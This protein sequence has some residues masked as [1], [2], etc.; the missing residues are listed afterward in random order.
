MQEADRVSSTLYAAVLL[1]PNSVSE[2]V[3]VA[4]QQASGRWFYAEAADVDVSRIPD[5]DQRARL[6]ARL[7]C[8]PDTTF[9]QQASI[10]AELLRFVQRVRGSGELTIRVGSEL[11]RKILQPMLAAAAASAGEDVTMVTWR[12]CRYS[13]TALD[14]FYKKSG[15]RRHA[16]EH[17]LVDALGLAICDLD[18]S[19]PM[20]VERIHHLEMVLG[21]KGAAGYRAWGRQ[22]EA[23]R[24]R[25]LYPHQPQAFA[26]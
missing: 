12:M 16:F 5:E 13:N 11:T 4:L 20:D 1:M 7:R 10:G 8:V 19:E 26:A 17:S 22:H 2:M 15:W 9:V 25:A 24:A 18:R 23:F 3:S 14:A 6:E 21:T